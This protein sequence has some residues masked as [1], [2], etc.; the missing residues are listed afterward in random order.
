MAHPRIMF[1]HDGRHPLIYM[2]EPPMQR[3]EYE[4]AVDELIGTPVEAIMFCLGD[5]R[6]VLHDTQVG[7]LWETPNKVWAHNIFRRAHQNAVHLI[8]KGNDPLKVVCDRA[9]QKGFLLYPTLL[10]QQASGERGVDTRG[11]NFRFDNKH[12]EIGAGS[13]GDDP[14]RDV[15]LDFKHDEVRAERFALIEETLQNYEV[16]GLELQ[17]NYTPYYFHSSEMEAGRQIMTDWIRR[18][19]AAVKG[20]G[21]ERELVLRVDNSIARCLVEGMD[22][23]AWIDA[24]IVD[25]LVPE[26]RGVIDPSADFREILEAAEGSSCRVHGTLDHTVDSDRLSRATIEITRA[27]ATNYW[28]QGIDGLYLTQWFTTWPYDANFYE[29]LREV[30][31]PEVMAPRD[32]YYYVPTAG[33]RRLRDPEPVG[34][35][36]RLP[37]KLEQGRTSTIRFS[38]SDDLKRWAAVGRVH[39]VLLRIRITGSTEIDKFR[40]EFNGE[41]LPDRLQRKI[42]AMYT[43]GA[44]RFRVG[45]YW[46]IYKLE[47]ENWP[48]QGKNEVAV[49]L[50][51][52]DEAVTQQPTLNDVELETKYLKGKNFHRAFVDADL[53]P[54]DCAVL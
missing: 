51:H 16:D 33:A 8:E 20:S 10:L 22:L 17:L 26:N 14:L 54:Y 38:V 44:P 21:S 9:H 7:E 29:K 46:F 36:W 11:S 30:T 1:Y 18:V 6:T 37:M 31:D 52:L 23:R 47:P 42:N 35:S 13:S 40:F 48:V 27:T 5:G 39:E 50:V 3:E 19:H 15:C 41:E 43:L 12:L 24:G 25:V 2:Y 53:G 4:Q 34:V 28:R 45:G 32:K 49:S